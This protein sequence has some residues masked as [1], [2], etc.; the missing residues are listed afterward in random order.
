[1]NSSPKSFIFHQAMAPNK[2]TAKRWRKNNQER[3]RLEVFAMEYL[4][5]K[6]PAILTDIQ[7]LYERIN[8]KYPKKRKLT[9]TADFQV[10]KKDN[11]ATLTSSATTPST[12][13]DVTSDVGVQPSEEACDV[14]VQPSEE[15]SIGPAVT[16]LTMETVTTET[17]MD[18]SDLQLGATSII[19]NEDSLF[20]AEIQSLIEELRDDPDL[21]AIMDLHEQQT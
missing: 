1:M 14:G 4:K 19:G 18:S 11:E 8:S 16:A 17:I 3:H 7:A 10:W 2:E 9:I 5:C 13:S 15:A 21:R 12:S 20:D 6:H